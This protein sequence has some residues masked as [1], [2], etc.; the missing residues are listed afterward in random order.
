MRTDKPHAVV[1]DFD[2]VLA[3]TEGLH[4]AAFQD[5]FADR[6][7]TLDR[8]AYFERYLGY[9]DRD[10]LQLYLD[11]H[12]IALS[13]ADFGALL[14]ERARRFEH[15]V[16]SGQVLFPTATSAV[17]RLGAHYRLAIASGSMRSE[18]LGILNANGLTP[19]FAAVVGC[20][21]VPKSK[22]APDSYAAAVERLGIEPRQAVAIEDSH[23]GI[24]AAKAAG[25]RAIGLTTSS[26]AHVLRMADTVVDSLDDITPEFV[27]DLL[28]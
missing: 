8:A 18:I 27:R 4:L 5:V 14:R 9:D 10:M 16:A 23:W 11:D 22:P 17:K 3:D 2:G 19:E 15:R 7:W 1:F 25:L 12:S 26:T 13:S 21:D 24:T 28:R 6:G 20:D